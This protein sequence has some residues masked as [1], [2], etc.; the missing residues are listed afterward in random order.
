MSVK[1]NAKNVSPAVSDII[2]HMCLWLRN[3][4]AFMEQFR[5]RVNYE[6]SSAVLILKPL[7]FSMSFIIAL[8]ERINWGI[9]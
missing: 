8:E 5:C 9:L 1:K 7:S 2:Y 6:H 4:V 3:F